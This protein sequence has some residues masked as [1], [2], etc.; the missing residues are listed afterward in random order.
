MLRIAERIA[1]HWR[2]R[3]LVTGEVIGQVA[4]QTLE[5]MAAIAEAT[6][7]EVLRPLVGMDK[8][9]ITREAERI[10]TFPISII[11]DQDCCTLFTPRHPAT[12]ARP[13]DVARAE[14]ALPIE[15]MVSAAVGAVSVEQ[16]RFPVLE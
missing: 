12:R 8:D 3:T 6:T 10:G 7:L 16:F 9:E 5:N 4:S 15:E 13:T 11:P 14:Q 2:A 1:R